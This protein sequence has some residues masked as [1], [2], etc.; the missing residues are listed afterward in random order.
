MKQVG[1][2]KSDVLWFV[3]SYNMFKVTK[4]VFSRAVFSTLCPNFNFI[5][6]VSDAQRK[7]SVFQKALTF[8][9]KGVCQMV[10]YQK[11]KLL[12][13]LSHGGGSITGAVKQ[14]H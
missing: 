7:H 10:L 1:K 12:F 8:Y 4:W 14:N 9:S 11:Q 6:K 2:T 3:K 13:L 5:N